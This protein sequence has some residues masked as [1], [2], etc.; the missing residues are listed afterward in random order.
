VV[1]VTSGWAAGGSLP[2]APSVV[3]PPWPRPFV[4]RGR[5]EA[6]E[7]PGRKSDPSLEDSAEVA[8]VAEPDCRGDAVCRQSGRAEQRPS[9]VD[10]QP[11]D[12][13]RERLVECRAE[14]AS[15]VVGAAGQSPRDAGS[16]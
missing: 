14:H 6:A 2:V 9:T 11:M 10:A 1:P 16:A 4:L 7:L 5:T 15:Q 3:N 8:H 12:V 13:L